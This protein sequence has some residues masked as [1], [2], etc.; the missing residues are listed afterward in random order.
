MERMGWTPCVSKQLSI[1]L[2]QY[3]PLHIVPN[4]FLLGLLLHLKRKWWHCGV[5]GQSI[6]SRLCLLHRQDNH[7]CSIHHEEALS[8]LNQLCSIINLTEMRDSLLRQNT[9]PNNDASKSK[10]LHCSY[11]LSLYIKN[12]SQ[13]KSLNEIMG[14]KISTNYLLHQ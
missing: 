6:N 5:C 9:L 4:R 13:Q 2:V 7:F 8:F 14:G 1:R 11:M 3:F 12:K 10:S